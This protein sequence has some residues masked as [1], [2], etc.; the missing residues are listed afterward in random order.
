M[1]TG[2]DYQESWSLTANTTWSKTSSY[3]K[4]ITVYEA[5]TNNGILR[6]AGGGIVDVDVWCWCNK[7]FVYLTHATCPVRVHPHEPGSHNRSPLSLSYWCNGWIYSPLS[8]G[9][10]NEICLL[11]WPDGP[12]SRPYPLGPRSHLWTHSVSVTYPA[13]KSKNLNKL[14]R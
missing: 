9:H 12:E 10:I 4:K 13:R 5:I 8:Q 2:N 7:E 6:R 11:D 1:I 3:H 14:L